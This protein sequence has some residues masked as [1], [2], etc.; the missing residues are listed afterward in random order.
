MGMRCGK[1]LT[2][3]WLNCVASTDAVDVTGMLMKASDN[4]LYD[5]PQ[6]ALISGRDTRR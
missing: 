3:K 1:R 4:R 2:T 6:A 5:K